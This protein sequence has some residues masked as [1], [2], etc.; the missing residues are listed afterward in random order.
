MPHRSQAW[1]AVVWSDGRR[2]L[3]YSLSQGQQQ[4]EQWLYHGQSCDLYLH[5]ICHLHSEF[6]VNR[7][8]RRRD[9]DITS[10]WR[11]PNL[12]LTI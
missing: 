2:R 11:N 8:I 6:R 4:H 5:V 3:L 7:P 12:V 1:S 10:F 9:I